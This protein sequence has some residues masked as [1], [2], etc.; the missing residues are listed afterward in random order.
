VKPE[1]ISLG[2]VGL[3]LSRALP[4][5]INPNANPGDRI[6]DKITPKIGIR[7]NK[8]IAVQ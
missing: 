2:A 4:R 1:I 8:N 7:P 6:R 5:E 3:L